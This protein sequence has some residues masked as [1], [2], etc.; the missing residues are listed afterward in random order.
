MQ[1]NH[2]VD[3]P[4][5]AAYLVMTLKKDV[6]AKDLKHL[7]ES[8]LSRL[9]HAY[10]REQAVGGKEEQMLQVDKEFLE[11]ASSNGTAEHFKEALVLALGEDNAAQIPRQDRWRSIASKAKPTALAAILK[12]ER[13]EVV[14]IVLS[15]LPADYS[16]EL[17]FHLP[18]EVLGRSIECLATSAPIASAAS[19]ALAQALEEAL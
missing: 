2:A 15:K 1:T 8:E 4:T 11:A 17:I 13:P 3:E 5:K 10:E 14:G 19:D 7:N 18:P 9:K 6:L 12:D 16:A